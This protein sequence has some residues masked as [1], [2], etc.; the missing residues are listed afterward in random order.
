M[1]CTVLFFHF[2]DEYQFTISLFL[3]ED[4]KNEGEDV[5]VIERLYGR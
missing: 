1:K 4:A 2:A 3:E 5:L